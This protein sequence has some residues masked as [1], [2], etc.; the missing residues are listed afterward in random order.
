MKSYELKIYEIKDN[1]VI[2]T[3]KHLEIN[4]LTSNQ[5]GIIH[6]ELL[7]M[8]ITDLNYK[9]SLAQDDK[10]VKVIQHLED[11]FRLLIERKNDR[12]ARNVL[13]TNKQ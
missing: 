6:E 5:S 3:N 10:T 1:Q 13:N 2:D 4:I 8:M 11:A 9:Q 7:Q 12:I